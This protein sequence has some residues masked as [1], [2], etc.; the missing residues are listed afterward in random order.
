MTFERKNIAEMQGYQSGEQPDDELTIKLNTNENPYPASP[1]VDEV[2]RNLNT[3][4]LRRYPPPTAENFRS[5]AADLHNVDVENIIATRG[6][7][8]LLRLVITTF[9]DP[10][11]TI[12]MSDPSYS[13]YPVLAQIQNCP[14]LPIPLQEDWSLPDDFIT[15]VNKA[16]SKLTFI[17]NPHAPTGRLLDKPTIRRLAEG[18]N[19]ILLVDEA[20]V[21]FVDPDIQH[22]CLDLIKEFDNLIFLRTLSK[23]YSL[24]GLRFGYGIAHSKIIKPMLEK[25][26]D[27]YNL[28]FFS[29]QI[30]AAALQDQSYARSTWQKVRNEKSRLVGQLASL[31][32]SS[33]ESESNFILVTPDGQPEH[34]ALRLY[35][36]L[37]E[38]NILV[39]HFDV[40]GL[41]DKLRITVGTPEE[42]KLLLDAISGFF[43]HQKNKFYLS[44][45]NTYS[46]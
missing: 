45:N 19:S 40:P 3:E 9:V 43:S 39:R 36:Y 7:D 26:K 29:Q 34:S 14:I 18:I 16:N 44:E 12:T 21:D 46:T 24:A 31:G 10:E 33:I 37:K 13:L 17:V 27:S 42:N 22:H 4:N 15:Q 35:L 41:K 11:E 2:V 1:K 30:A 8:E 23:G 25:T 28:D 20:Y 32:F 38:N 5:V 6:G